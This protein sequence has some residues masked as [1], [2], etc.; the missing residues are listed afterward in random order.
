MTA[1]ALSRCIIWEIPSL[2]TAINQY[3]IRFNLETFRLYIYMLIESTAALLSSIAL[4]F[5]LQRINNFCD[6]N[7][8]SYEVMVR[9]SRAVTRIYYRI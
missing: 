7:D 8:M 1:G 6:E 3:S 4:T 5:L 9:L 2:T